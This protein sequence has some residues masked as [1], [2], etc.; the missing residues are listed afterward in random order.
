[1]VSVDRSKNAIKPNRH[2]MNHIMG[3]PLA[4]SYWKR[5]QR[6]ENIYRQIQCCRWNQTDKFNNRADDDDM[7]ITA[8][9]ITMRREELNRWQSQVGIMKPIVMIEIAMWKSHGDWTSFLLRWISTALLVSPLLHFWIKPDK[10]HTTTI[11]LDIYG[12][13]HRRRMAAFWTTAYVDELSRQEYLCHLVCPIALVNHPTMKWKRSEA[14]A[15]T[16]YNGHYLQPTHPLIRMKEYLPP[17]NWLSTI[18]P[19]HTTASLS[20]IKP[21]KLQ[22]SFLLLN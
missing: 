18:R 1:M 20:W 5:M 4:M 2:R 22:H 10:Q 13:I 3:R 8:S 17:F 15:L 16:Q 21:D 6:W 7:D 12:W 14:E 9:I 19:Y 11:P